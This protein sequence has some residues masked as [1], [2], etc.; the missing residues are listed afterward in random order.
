MSDVDLQ[1]EMAALADAQI[2][3]EASSKLLHEV[4]GRKLDRTSEA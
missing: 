1:L 3:Y 4:Y 2:R